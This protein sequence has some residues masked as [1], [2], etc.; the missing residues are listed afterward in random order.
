MKLVSAQSVGWQSVVSLPHLKKRNLGLH[1]SVCS[2]VSSNLDNTST[3]A[4]AWTKNISEDLRR[5]FVIGREVLSR[6]VCQGCFVAFLCADVPMLVSAERFV[7]LHGITQV[8]ISYM[9]ALLILC[10]CC[11]LGWCVD[12]Q[13]LEVWSSSTIQ[14]RAG[15]TTHT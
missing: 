13:S 7:K 2:Q 15:L 10:N 1:R 14:N 11:A 6:C 5:R 4:I 8:Q 3:E 12:R 9:K